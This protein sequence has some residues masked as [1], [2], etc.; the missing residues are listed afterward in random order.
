M[1][2]DGYYLGV[3]FRRDVGKEVS[4]ILESMRRMQSMVERKRKTGGPV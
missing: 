1:C 4:G 3:G 2:V